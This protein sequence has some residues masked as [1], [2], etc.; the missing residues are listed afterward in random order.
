MLLVAVGV[1]LAA[2]D[3]NPSAQAPQ[4]RKLIDSRIFTERA[5]EG[6]TEQDLRNLELANKWFGNRDPRMTNQSLKQLQDAEEREARDRRYG[7]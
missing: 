5:K 3:A 6:P 1:S 7:R 4:K 2:C